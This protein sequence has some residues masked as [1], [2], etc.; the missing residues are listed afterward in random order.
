MVSE[1]EWLQKTVEELLK[2]VE[3]KV[4]Q[5]YQLKANNLFFYFRGI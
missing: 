3:Q 5:D 2:H 4:E 1:Q